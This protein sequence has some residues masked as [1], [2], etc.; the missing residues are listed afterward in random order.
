MV[1]PVPPTFREP[2]LPEPE[3]PILTSLDFDVLEWRYAELTRAGYLPVAAMALAERMD[4]DL[5]Q[6]CELLVG[7]CS[8][9]R[10][11]AILL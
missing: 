9:E 3:Q 10:A 11:L 6:A 2:E 7:G 5:H 8:P 4:V 1:A